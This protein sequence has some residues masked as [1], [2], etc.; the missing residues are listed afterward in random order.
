MDLIPRKF[1]LDDIFDDFMVPERTNVGKCDIYE[2]DN[3][4]HIEMDVPGFKK[5]D[6]KINLD[7]N[8]LTIFAEKKSEDKD[9]SKK[10]IRKERTYSKFE[11]SIYLGDADEENIEAEYKD[12]ILNII[13]PKI[14]ENRTKKY[15]EIK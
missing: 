15:I 10:Y 4:Y 2:K 6:I 1:Y 8:Y 14:N 5:E 9:E 12:G 7:N 11:R 13:V 3:K